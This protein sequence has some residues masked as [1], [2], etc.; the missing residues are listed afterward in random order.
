MKTPYA[1]LG[2]D[3]VLAA[4]ESIGYRTD[5]G[6][7]ALNSFENRVW[8]VGLDTAEPIIAKFYRPGRWSNAAIGE[9]HEFAAQLASADLSVVAPLVIDG[10]T[11]HEHAGYRFA[12]FPRQGG[13]AP[14]PAHEPTLRTLGRALGRMHAVGA[15]ARFAHRPT[16]SIERLG[17]NSM[18]E[19]LEGDWIPAHLTTAFSSLAEHLLEAVEAAWARA[20]TLTFIRLHGDC[21]PGNILWRDD[22]AHFV[23]LDDCLSG[24]AIQDLWML[25]SGSRAERERQLDWL[26]GAYRMFY[27]FD[28]RELQLVEA[29]RTL[30]MLHYQAWLARRWVDP[31]FPAAFPWFGE[32]R[33]W[34]QVIGQLR[35]QLG[36]LSEPPLNLDAG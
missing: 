29:L 35:D 31:A 13:H 17:R 21:H 25:I 2:P 20:G 32:S 1:N 11:L 36:E 33:H 23:D 22:Q 10:Q 15:S 14:E 7:L 3:V 34:E 18:T 30:R 27:D 16:I 9:E 6:L 24:P 12:L 26:I 4:I 8:Q 19:L 5:G 28:P